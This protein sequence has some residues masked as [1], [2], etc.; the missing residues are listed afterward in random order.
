[1]LLGNI[2]HKN[3]VKVNVSGGQ[4]GL[5]YYTSLNFLDDRGVA[6]NSW[7]QRLQ[8]RANVDFQASPKFKFSSNISF[9]WTNRNKTSAGIP[10]S[11]YLTGQ[12]T[13]GFTCRMVH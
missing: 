12:I 3:D 4:K 6:L 7:A 2:A 10:L 5:T 1:M 13:L 8:G 11:R 9:A